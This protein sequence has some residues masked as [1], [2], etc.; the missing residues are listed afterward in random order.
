M[1]KHLL[2]LGF[3]LIACCLTPQQSQAQH[4]QNAV[5]ARLGY[6]LAAS[7]KQFISAS[8][9]FEVYAGFRGWSYGSWFSISGAYQIHNDLSEI[10]DGLTWYYGAGGSVYF[11]SFKTGFGEGDATTA[12]AIQGYLGLEYTFDDT[13]LSVS[14]DWVPSFFINGYGSGFGGGYGALAARYILNR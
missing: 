4:Y 3:L 5:G 8:S 6:P 12:F 13:P 11:W 14:V 7:Y 9:A 1:K 10:T 2:F